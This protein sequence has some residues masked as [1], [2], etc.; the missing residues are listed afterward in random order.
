MHGPTNV[1]FLGRLT[2]LRLQTVVTVSL[3]T[4]LQYSRNGGWLTN[5]LT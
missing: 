1:I 4:N 2:I 5:L 3:N